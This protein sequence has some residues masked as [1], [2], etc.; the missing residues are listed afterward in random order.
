MALKLEFYLNGQPIDEP[1]NYQEISIELN[2]DT[3]DPDFRGYLAT[4]NWEF[5]LGTNDNRDATKII[6]SWLGGQFGAF[7][8]LKYEVRL[9]N[10][11]KTETLLDAYIDLSTAEY[12]CDRIVADSQDAKGL[13]WFNEVSNVP[14]EY[15]YKETDIINNSDFV[16]IPYKEYN[17]AD[18]T[19][20]A[21]IVLTIATIAI[22]VW[23]FTQQIIAFIKGIKNA[24]GFNADM[25]LIVFEL[26]ISLIQLIITISIFTKQIL[27]YLKSPTKYKA[28]MYLTDLCAKGAEYFGYTFDSTI[29]RGVKYSL[30]NT[31]GFDNVVLIPESYE[32]EVNNEDGSLGIQDI[33]NGNLL[34]GYYNGT[35]KELLLELKS[36]FNAKIIIDQT[37]KVLRLERRDYGDVNNTYQIP[38]IDR[39]DSPYLFNA[40]DLKSTYEVSYL[41]DNQDKVSL[42]NYLGTEIKAITTPYAT[43]GNFLMTGEE[44]KII[45][46]GLTTLKTDLTK[47]EKFIR[48]ISIGYIAFIN[49]PI[50]LLRA[51]L[52]GLNKIIKLFN[53]ILKALKTVGVFKREIKIPLINVDV[54]KNPVQ[55]FKDQFED[56][57]LGMLL[58]ETDYLSTPKL[59]ALKD[60]FSTFQL[61]GNSIEYKPHSNQRSLLNADYLYNNFHYING[62]VTS[63]GVRDNKHNQNK[64][65]TLTNIPFCLDE[66]NLVKNNPIIRDFDGKQGEMISVKWNIYRETAD[67]TF[68]VNEKYTNNL[69]IKTVISDGR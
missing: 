7:E 10:G 29:L 28:G 31:L 18:K 22:Q 66:Y 15:L 42:Q 48:N 49:A 54:I 5:G 59:V 63:P 17:P 62:F 25:L 14:F 50:L 41:K 57:K 6:K 44:V 13:D 20:A 68:K 12:L 4:N 24:G 38:P 37:N 27:R 40:D 55:D 64:I 32:Q 16:F 19:Q 53:K 39:T 52:K 60:K 26:L 35:Y 23:S 33:R 8:G 34:R 3:N 67:I 47:Q 61:R 36:M 69:Q 58:F 1:L 21:V 51:I 2:N 56:D 45:N 65:Y 9:R 43:R 30:D 11:S 46:F